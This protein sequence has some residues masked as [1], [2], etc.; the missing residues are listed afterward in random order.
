MNEKEHLCSTWDVFDQ[1]Y[2]Y[3]YHKYMY[4]QGYKNWIYQTWAKDSLDTCDLSLVIR[5]T[6]VMALENLKLPNA[7]LT[8]SWFMQSF[9]DHSCVLSGLFV[10]SFPV[11]Y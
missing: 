6:I 2:L 9:I 11:L 8:F 5:K 4:Q 10:G 3:H 1:F 7:M